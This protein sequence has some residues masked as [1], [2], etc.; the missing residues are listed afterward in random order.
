MK[1]SHAVA[2]ALLL[3]LAAAFGVLAAG[4]TAR[5]GAASRPQA[6]ASSVHARVQQ[7]DKAEAALRRALHQRPPALPPLP[8]VVPAAVA[9]A[10]PRVVY[11]RPAPIVVVR[12]SAHHDDSGESQSGG[13]FDD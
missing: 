2:V 8:A 7:L 3:G 5:L 4:K 9:T 6:A 13:G 1:K 10:A 12:H 11:R